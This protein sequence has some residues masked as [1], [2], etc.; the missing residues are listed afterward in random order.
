MG[1]HPAK[2]IRPPPDANGVLRQHQAL[3]LLPPARDAKQSSQGWEC[4]CRWTTKTGNTWNK[5]ILIYQVK[6]WCQK[7]IDNGL[8]SERD[9]KVRHCCGVTHARERPGQHLREARI[10][11]H[12]NSLPE[13]KVRQPS[14]AGLL[15]KLRQQTGAKA[16]CFGYKYAKCRQLHQEVKE[17]EVKSFQ[18]WISGTQNMER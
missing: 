2:D 13:C 14:E 5:S 18:R 17:D 3:W 4:I 12:L 11:Q 7:T 6:F 10:L 16:S 8:K 9:Q 1:D 15:L